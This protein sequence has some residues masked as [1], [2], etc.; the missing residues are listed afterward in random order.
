MS[1]SNDDWVT[2]LMAKLQT[3][4]NGKLDVTINGKLV[5]VPISQDLIQF[6]LANKQVLTTLGLDLFRQFLDLLQEKKQQDAFDLLLSAMSIDEMINRL[7]MDAA[8]LASDN[9][10]RDDFIAALEKFAEDELVGLAGKAIMALLG[11]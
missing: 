5:E 2:Q 1:D 4:T 10:H 6:F 9:Q 3:I 11:F 8:Q 7:N